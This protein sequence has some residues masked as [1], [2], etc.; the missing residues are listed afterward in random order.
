[1]DNI[2]SVPFVPKC[3]YGML[4]CPNRQAYNLKK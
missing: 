4:A 1:M 3:H 2:N